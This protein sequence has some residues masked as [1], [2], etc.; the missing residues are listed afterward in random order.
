MTSALDHPLFAFG[1][2]TVPDMMILAILV[3]VLFGAKKLPMF[4]R[5]LGRSMSDFRQAK[6]DFER[7]L[8]ETAPAE[9]LRELKQEDPH[10]RANFVISIIF[11]L[12]LLFLII[13][14][15]DQVMAQH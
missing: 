3:L 10:A 11:F 13:S 7:E 9:R 15:I 4:G 12:S 2:P 8:R 14:I 1:M 5:G 6:E